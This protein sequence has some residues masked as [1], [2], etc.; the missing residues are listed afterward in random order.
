[1]G[2]KRMNVLNSLAGLAIVLVCIIAW[3]AMNAKTKHCF[4][5]LYLF[6]G[7]CGAGI[8]L[9]PHFNKGL[10]EWA[11]TALIVAFT[12]LMLM[13]RFHARRID[14][15]ATRPGGN[16]DRASG[17]FVAVAMV[18]FATLALAPQAV[19]A[20]PRVANDQE[21]ASAAEVALVAR[22]AAELEL[23]APTAAALL[24]KVFVSPDRRTD[25]LTRLIQAAAY[26][27]NMSAADFAS[28]LAVTCMLQDGNVDS[29]LGEGV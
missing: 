1:M 3:G 16:F 11:Q 7:F 5:F 8:V 22:A 10:A 17:L 23:T 2:E 19:H 15:E 6:I 24:A 14:P 9:L 4:R 26:R 18:A 12:L 27:S 28:I 25:E 20:A 29:I 13:D 21:C